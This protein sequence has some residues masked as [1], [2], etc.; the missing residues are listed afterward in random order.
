MLAWDLLAE[1]SKSSSLLPSHPCDPLSVKSIEKG[2]RCRTSFMTIIGSA[3]HI[4]RKNNHRSMASKRLRRVLVTSQ[5]AQ[6]GQPWKLRRC[7]FQKSPFQ[8]DTY[9]EVISGFKFTS[10]QGKLGT[11]DH[12]YTLLATGRAS[13]EYF[14]ALGPR[15]SKCGFQ[16]SSSE[17]PL[18]MQMLRTPTGGMETRGRG[19]NGAMAKPSR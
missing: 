7:H 6:P 15:F 8:V 9:V 18:E 13:Q 17:N 1:S 10:I 19:P 14:L 11:L 3:P 2:T 16:T 12:I 4:S 5:P